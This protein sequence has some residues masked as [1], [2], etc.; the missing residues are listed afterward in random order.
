[1][2][3]GI[4][5]RSST[6]FLVACF[7][8]SCFLGCGA[9]GPS[10]A[11]VSGKVTMDGQPLSGV[12]VTFTPVDGGVSSSGLTDQ[13]G[14]YQLSCP[15]GSGALVGKHRVYVRSQPPGSAMSGEVPSEDDPTY[16]PDP[17]AS[18]AAKSFEEK[19][20]ARYNTKSELV[21]E[22][23]PGKNVIDLELTSKP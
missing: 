11:P 10:L 9:Q 1:M 16:K 8:V 19:I 13:A 3:L 17:Y 4:F 23:K 7:A 18:V 6:S 5:L 2:S 15:L 20:P 14:V 22:V 21:R 12:I